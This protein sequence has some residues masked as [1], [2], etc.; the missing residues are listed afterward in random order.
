[1]VAVGA[2]RTQTG[3]ETA[4]INTVA[5]TRGATARQRTS[6]RLRRLPIAEQT[7]QPAYGCTISSRAVFSRKEG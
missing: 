3:R 5:H 4:A 1:M 2:R 7:R 6:A